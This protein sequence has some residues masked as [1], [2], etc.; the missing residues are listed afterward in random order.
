[1]RIWLAMLVAPA[2]ALADQSVAVAAADW[3]CGHQL[4]I[5]VHVVHMLFLLPVAA[6]IAMAWQ[7]RGEVAL[8]AGGAGDEK[9]VQRQFLAGIAAASATISALA[10]LAMWLT[11]WFVAPCYA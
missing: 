6:S 3:A 11:T 1:M 2:L 10:I 7:A 5:A 9:L 8:P 4:P